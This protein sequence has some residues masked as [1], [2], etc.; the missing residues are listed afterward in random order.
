MNP[1][2]FKTLKTLRTEL[3]QGEYTSSELIQSICDQLNPALN[4]T[5]THN[6]FI[7]FTP[8]LA[9]AQAKKADLKI[10]AKQAGLLTGLP[11]GHKDLFCTQGIKTTCASKML[12]NFIAPYNATVVDKTY[13]AGM[14]LVG[15]L[16][17]DEFA[18]GASN[19]HSY[20][21]PVTNP[22]DTKRSPGGSS[23]GSAAAV[24][25]GLIPAATGTD[26]GGSIRQ[27]AALCGITG[28]KPTYGRVSRYGMIAFASS[29]DSGGP[30]ARTAE[31]CAMLLAGIAGFDPKDSTSIQRPVDN[32][33]AQLDRPIKGL[34]IGVLSAFQSKYLHPHIQLQF[35]E[36]FRELENQ[37]AELIEVDL[38]HAHLGIAVYYILAPAEASSNLARYDGV[39]Y[40]HRAESPLGQKP[41]DLEE[42]YERSRQEGFGHEVKRRIMLGSFV[43]SS[44]GYDAYYLKAQKVR[45]L[46]AQD[47][48]KAFEKVD[49]IVGPT[50]PGTASLIGEHSQDATRAYLEDIFTLPI[51]LAGLPAISLPCGIHNGLPVGF[52]II[53]KAFDEA[54]ILQ[55]AHQ[56]QLATDWHNHHPKNHK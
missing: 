52:Q 31:D 22:W 44:Q 19:E 47:F 45:R 17:M 10:Q 43:L 50:A 51:N 2:Q 9:L 11:I 33:L 35:K 8:E 4:L 41:Y 38:P 24:A 46:I 1:Y 39:R 5:D 53:G 56:F 30:M 23:G 40:G 26:T 28:L 21:G 18:M 42:F 29:L 3:D 34:K 6:A 15:K 20:F 12:E 14:C 16:N 48:A 7:S 49:L 54:R 13:E 37:G 55:C 32:Y 36:A 25:S 27:P